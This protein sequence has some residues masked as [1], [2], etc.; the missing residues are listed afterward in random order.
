VLK[1]NRVIV[2]RDVT[3]DESK[4]YD[5]KDDFIEDLELIVQT[6]KVPELETELEAATNSEISIYEPRD[7]I[8]VD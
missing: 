5:L 6:I 4:V 8:I 1:L 2:T 3:F 7:S